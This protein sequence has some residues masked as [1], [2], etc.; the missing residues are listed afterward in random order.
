[1]SIVGAFIVPHPPVIIPEVG[2]GKEE[3]LQKTDAAYREV[4]D[5]IAELQPDTIVL[6]SSH[7]ASFVNYFCIT[8]DERVKGSFKQFGA[9][10]VTV[11]AVCDTLFVQALSRA[12][13]QVH[14]PAG[15]STKKEAELD[16]GTMIPL[17][18]INQVYTDYK[19]VRMGQSALSAPEHYQL[20]KLI[21]QT[22]DQLDRRVVVVASGDLSHRLS[23]SS[24]YGFSR[25][26]AKFDKEVTDVM[27]RG[28]FLRWLTIPPQV[29]REVGECGLHAY[30]VL[31]GTLDSRAVTPR[32]LSY[33][34]PFGV[35]Y[36]VASFEV[37]D[38]DATRR[39][40]AAYEQ[41]ELVRIQVIRKNEDRY[42]SLA[43]VALEGY[44]KTGQ[45]I[46]IASG[47]PIDMSERRAGAFVTVYKYGRMRGCAGSVRPVTESVADEIIRSAILACKSDPRFPAVTVDE[48]P[49]LVY[50]V[51][52]LSDVEPVERADEVDLK[53]FG[54]LITSGKKNS[55][56]MP[57]PNNEKSAKEQVAAAL[58]KAGIGKYEPYTLE[59]FT[60][61]RH[62]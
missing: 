9:E 60:M 8:P 3:Q 21:A 57:D 37:G 24:P 53:N 27:K 14:F 58:E 39:F 10:N 56:L 62:H 40:D 23:E 30:Q 52:I 26:G 22:A 41:R 12:A 1:M 51:D 36:S 47:L 2:R 38:E 5:R 16:F 35:G 13:A 54:I 32:L 19:L 44:V 42:A 55:L 17:Y 28:D 48:L 25:T 34:A 18:F 20:G 45:G 4:A 59:R 43:R 7:A 29:C 6:L 61:V 33:E 46:R 11:E 15:F 49:D 31:A 50:T